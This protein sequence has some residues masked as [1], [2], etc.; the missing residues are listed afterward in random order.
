MLKRGTRCAD[1]N[2]TGF[3]RFGNFLDQVNGQ[4]PVLQISAAY[5]DKIGKVELALEAAVGNR[6][7]C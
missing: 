5:L 7:T 2:R 6:A 3:H 4:Q 1:C